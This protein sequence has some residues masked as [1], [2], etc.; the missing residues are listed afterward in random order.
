MDGRPT[1][2]QTPIPIAKPLELP[3]DVKAKLGVLP[4]E[5]LAF[6]EGGL[7]GR[8]V[9][10]DTLFER[11]R[12]MPEAELIAYITTFMS[13]T[14]GDMIV[15]GTPTGAGARFIILGGRDGDS[16]VGLDRPE[17]LGE[18]P[19]NYRGLLLIEDMYGTGRAL[20]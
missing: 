1:G 8:Y 6:I 19:R 15:T 14:P 9:E 17:Q 13:L 12:E 7:S 10:K 3:D 11:A 20:Q 4:A 5:H 16:L 18:V 2:R